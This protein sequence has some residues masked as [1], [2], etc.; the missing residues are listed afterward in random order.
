M[1][2]S[3][4]RQGIRGEFQNPPNEIDK[5]I[6]ELAAIVGVAMAVIS[7]IGTFFALLLLKSGIR[8]TIP[9][10][11]LVGGISGL[12]TYLY[13]LQVLRDPSAVSVDPEMQKM[14]E[15]FQKM[16]E[17]SQKN[18]QKMKIEQEAAKRKAEEQKI[19]RLVKL[20]NEMEKFDLEMDKIHKEY[21]EKLQKIEQELKEAEGYLKENPNYSYPTG[22]VGDLTESENEKA[23]E[24]MSAEEHLSGAD[25]KRKFL[26]DNL[27]MLIS[28]QEMKIG[29]ALNAWGLSKEEKEPVLNPYRAKYGHLMPK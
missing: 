12:I 17:E 26:K 27:K 3:P 25:S 6:E 1:N 5:D 9:A 7:A 28:M 24:M 21:E 23:T 11:I 16:G 14:Q 8:A 2:I 20:K 13:T 22:P 4:E 18:I 29:Y 15:E 19:E 10:T